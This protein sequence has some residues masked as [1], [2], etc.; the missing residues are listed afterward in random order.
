MALTYLQLWRLAHLGDVSDSNG[1]S[2]KTLV[3]DARL[4]FLNFD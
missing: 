3:G 4:L 1:L 2:A